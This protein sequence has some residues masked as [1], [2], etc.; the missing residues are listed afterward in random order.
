MCLAWAKLSLTSERVFEWWWRL[1]LLLWFP[2]GG[3]EAAAAAESGLA[4]PLRRRLCV[5]KDRS[6]RWKLRELN[7]ENNNNNN[8]RRAHTST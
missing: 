8:R 5:N 7:D 4:G 1:L 3:E 2:L 6:S